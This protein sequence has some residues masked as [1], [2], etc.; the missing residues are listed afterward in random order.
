MGFGNNVERPLQIH[1]KYLISPSVW[2]FGSVDA[3][4][5]LKIRI[6]VLAIAGAWSIPA[7]PTKS[8]NTS[9]FRILFIT[10]SKIPAVS[11]LIWFL[12]ASFIWYR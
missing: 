10:I 9:P 8:S 12:P 1:V 6:R 11:F 3:W 5:F 4:F 7:S 2:C